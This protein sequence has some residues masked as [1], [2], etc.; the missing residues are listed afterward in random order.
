MEGMHLN[1]RVSGI[2]ALK[3]RGTSFIEVPHSLQT[4]ISFGILSTR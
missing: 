3:N 2:V 4:S 1:D